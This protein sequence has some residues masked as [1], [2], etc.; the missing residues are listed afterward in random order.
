VGLT[1][2]HDRLT[3]PL[4]DLRNRAMELPL[5]LKKCARVWPVGAC[6]PASGSE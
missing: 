5:H 3:R 2:P 1:F 6:L 4:A